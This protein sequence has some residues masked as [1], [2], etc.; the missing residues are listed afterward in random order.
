MSSGETDACTDNAV[1]ASSQRGISVIWKNSIP[2]AKSASV[3]SHRPS[4]PLLF[5]QKCH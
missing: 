2:I 4:P 5:P 3:K 1:A